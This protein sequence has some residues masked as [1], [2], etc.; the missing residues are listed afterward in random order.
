LK[1]VGYYGLGIDCPLQQLAV[2]RVSDHGGGGAHGCG[3]SPE[4]TTVCH[5]L[6]WFATKQPQP[7]T[8]YEPSH[9]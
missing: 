8:I 4:P 5:G 3:A 7:M 1:F 2:S 9:P 6:P